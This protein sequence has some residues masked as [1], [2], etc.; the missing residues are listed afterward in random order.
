MVSK[1]VLKIL[2]LGVSILM[3]CFLFQKVIAEKEPDSNK[4]I[5]ASLDKENRL[6]DCSKPRI[7]FVGGSNLAF[8]LDSKM[9]KQELKREVVNMGLHG[10]LG[11]RFMLN[12]SAE[13]IKK[14]DI[15]VLALEYYL[16]EEGD[17]KLFSEIIDFNK[18]AAKYVVRS[19]SD[20]L[21]LSTVTLQRNVF[22][23]FNRKFSKIPVDSLFRRNNFSEE[24]DFLGHLDIPF[25]GHFVYPQIPAA[26]YSNEIKRINDFIAD[27]DRK[28]AR[29]FYTFPNYPA[30]SFKLN[31]AAINSFETQIRK[32]V[33]CRVINTPETFVFPENYFFDTFYHLNKMGRAK[34][35]EKMVILLKGYIS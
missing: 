23:F 4:Y 21:K 3:V 2:L 7:V 9:I 32:G 27:A 30:L 11:L 31:K 15:I 6:R 14:G 25:A 19:I 12:E 35:T 13:N 33:H 17:Y 1:L 16:H 18:N 20:R 28:G 5:L 29:V 10:S 8:G 34:R 24:G 26:D 22:D